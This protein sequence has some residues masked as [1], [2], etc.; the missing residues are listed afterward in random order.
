M[1]AVARGHRTEVERID[2]IE[3]ADVVGVLGRVGAALVVRVDAAARAEE[4][5]GDLGVELIHAQ[6]V[7][8]LDDAQPRQRHRCDDAAAPPAQRA[9]AA[10]RIDDAIRQVEFQHHRAA[11]A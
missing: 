1:H 5:P 9:V 6:S 4:V 11:V 10:A 2:A 7:R 8:A 3:A